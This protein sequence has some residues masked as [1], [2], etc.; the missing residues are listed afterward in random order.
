MEEQEKMPVEP[1]KVASEPLVEP[2]VSQTRRARN[3]FQATM[4]KVTKQT[5]FV[6]FGT[7]LAGMLLMFG[8]MTVGSHQNHNFSSN[9]FG[10]NQVG[11]SSQTNGLPRSNSEGQTQNGKD[12]NSNHNGSNG[13]DTISGASQAPNT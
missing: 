10:Q 7:F 1:E 9:Q 12:S 5:L 8:A 13:S 6:S 2:T 4:Q 3:T 11:R